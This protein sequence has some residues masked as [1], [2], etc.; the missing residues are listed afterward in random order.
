MSF[1]FAH[2]VLL[3]V[4]GLL[5]LAWLVHLHF[6]KPASVTYPLASEL[7]RFAGETGAI[8]ARLPDALR[9]IAL[10]LLALAAG[11]PQ[12]YSVSEDV[13]SPGVD[14]M[15]CLDTSGSMAGLDFELDHKPVT[16]LTA[17]KKVVGEFI[18]Q[19]P[20]DRMGMVVFGQEAFSQAPLT[21]DKGLL[22]NLVDSMEIGMAGDST[23]IGQALAVAGK[24]LKDLKAPSKVIILLTDGNSNAGEVTPLEAATACKALGI[25]VYTIGVGGHGEAPFL[26]N[27]PFGRQLVHQRIDLNEEALREIAQTTGGQFFLASNTDALSKVYRTIDSLEKREVK[28]KEFFHYRELYLFFLVPALLLLLLGLCARLTVARVLP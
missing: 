23:A 20:H 15:L 24:R 28:T 11:R 1:R 25:K 17:V 8:L 2:P 4:L 10:I 5:L 14:I 6:R 12:T 18:G 22:L 9:I 16:R 13:L 21:M 26:V 19:R 7:A 27:T 3:A